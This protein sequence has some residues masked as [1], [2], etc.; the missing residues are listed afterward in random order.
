MSALSALGARV[1]H[2]VWVQQGVRRHLVA[3][4]LPIYT[5]DSSHSSRSQHQQD[6]GAP[7]DH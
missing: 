2:G 4:S 3:V 5:V 1:E 7:E 6:Y